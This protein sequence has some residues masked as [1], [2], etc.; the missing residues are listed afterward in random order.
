MKTIT[1]LFLSL[2]L[3][4]GLG[5]AITSQAQVESDANI[6]ANVPHSFVVNNTTLPAGNYVVTVV[7]TTDL[8]VLEIRSADDKLAVLFDTEP[9]N[10]N[11]LS[12]KSEL[13]F[14]QIGDTYFLARVFMSGDEGG[15]QL[16]KGKRQQ[17][18]E[19]G[20]VVAKQSS[21]AATPGEGKSSKHASRKAH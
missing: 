11:R 14:D 15:N 2:C 4:V 16:L 18:M 5:S 10:V 9:V 12:R 17:R 7:D 19:Q 13:V 20:G 21:I 1:K 8:N 3:L 6:R